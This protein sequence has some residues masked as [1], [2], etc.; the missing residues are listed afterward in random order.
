MEI[1]PDYHIE[2]ISL[3]DIIID[4]QRKEILNGQA[5][6]IL[7]QETMRIEETILTELFK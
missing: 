1:N 7:N 5:F 6:E 4:I 3:M 2:D